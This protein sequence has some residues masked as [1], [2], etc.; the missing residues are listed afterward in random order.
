M[1]RARP[2]EDATEGLGLATAR[3][4]RPTSTASVA[5]VPDGLQPTS[6]C[7]SPCDMDADILEY[8]TS[9]RHRS[10]ASAPGSTP[11]A[12][13]NVDGDLPMTHASLE[14]EFELIAQEIA[15]EAAAGTALGPRASLG[16]P[17]F[18]IPEDDGDDAMLLE[19]PAVPLSVQ[20]VAH[21]LWPPRA[22]SLAA[23]TVPAQLNGAFSGDEDDT[24][25]EQTTV[26]FA[27][28]FADE[29]FRTRSMRAAAPAPSAPAPAPPS[30]PFND[31]AEQAPE[32]PALALPATIP[33][34][35]VVI[36]PTSESTRSSSNAPDVGL[37]SADEP[38]DVAPAR[39]GF[40]PIAGGLRV[41]ASDPFVRTC[42]YDSALLRR[43]SPLARPPAPPK[44]A[45]GM[46]DTRRQSSCA[47]VAE[48][49]APHARSPPAVAASRRGTHLTAALPKPRP[50]SHTTFPSAVRRPTSALGASFHAL[51]L[52]RRGQCVTGTE[53]PG[54]RRS[55]AASPQQYG[56]A[57]QLARGSPTH[58]RHDSPGNVFERLSSPAHALRSG[59]AQ[60]RVVASPALARRSPLSSADATV[61]TDCPVSG[62]C[63]A[64]SGDGVC[65]PTTTR[66]LSWRCGRATSSTAWFRC[67]TTGAC[68]ACAAAALSGRAGSM[69]LLRRARLAL[70]TDLS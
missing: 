49:A 5:S 24:Q 9:P 22:L 6:E 66:R 15:A 51:P 68:R 60:A 61:H 1:E 2:A 64:G 45:A 37:E 41:E 59:T 48:E 40:V 70:R 36:S 21:M 52:E 14:D 65:R 4:P 47:V 16:V 67:M 53:A 39:P 25:L 42:S 23:P 29:L 55:E 44:S 57:Q 13:G 63:V 19:D 58:S 12:D 17:L 33:E 62:A 46:R 38:S 8:N 50:R 69:L 35:P 30:A 28:K 11:S 20:C 31:A 26:S 10:R 34:A 54:P 3:R 32:P 27:D 56:S 43:P 7:V 18:D